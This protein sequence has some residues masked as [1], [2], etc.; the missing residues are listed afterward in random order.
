MDRCAV[1]ELTNWHIG[2]M[3]NTKGAVTITSTSFID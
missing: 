2:L 3:S 1:H